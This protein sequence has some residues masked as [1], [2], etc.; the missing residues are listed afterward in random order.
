MLCQLSYTAYGGDR[1]RTCNPQF[2][3]NRLQ[4]T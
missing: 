4:S 3:D 1:T 2:R